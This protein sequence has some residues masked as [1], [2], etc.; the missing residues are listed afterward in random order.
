MQVTTSII[1]VDLTHCTLKT[2]QSLITKSKFEQFTYT[3]TIEHLS[4]VLKLKSAIITM[5][6]TQKIMRESI[7]NDILQTAY[8]YI[9]ER[10]VTITDLPSKTVQEL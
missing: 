6:M 10:R 4:A 9:T 2:L 7:K 3:I 1:R 8:Q 5:N